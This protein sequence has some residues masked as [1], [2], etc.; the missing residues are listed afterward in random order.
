MTFDEWY[1]QDRNDLDKCD[2]VDF[3]RAAWEDSRKYALSDAVQAV[4]IPRKDLV[5]T[6]TIAATE[7]ALERLCALRLRDL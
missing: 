7:E 4:K 1:E 3:A 6:Y 5:S 2:R